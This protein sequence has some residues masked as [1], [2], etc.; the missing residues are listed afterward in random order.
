[1]LGG[2]NYSFDYG[3][4]ERYFA[5]NQ[6]ALNL[7]VPVIL[8]GASVGPFSK[9]PSYETWAAEQ[10]RKVSRIY[11]REAFT[12]DYLKTIGIEENVVRVVD[13][14]FLME[15]CEADFPEDILTFC[16][17]GAVGLNISPLIARFR[18]DNSLDSWEKLTRKI[19]QQIIDHLNLPIILI[20]HVTT[21]SS[22]PANDDYLFLKKVWEGL[23]EQEK[24]R[25]ALLGDNYD[26]A[27]TKW[28]ISKLKGFVGARTHATIASLSSAV[29]TIVIAYSIKG[30]GIV[31]DVFNDG[32]WLIEASD[33][34][35]EV[36][37]NKLSCLMQKSVEV[38]TYL[39][40]KAETLRARALLAAQD[41]RNF[42]GN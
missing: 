42:L 17:E 24:Q 15:P 18:P 7:K 35:P 31:Q 34:S 1:M 26:A 36:L 5:L 8:W 22:N 37:I 3:Y 28:L 4:P 20:P 10:L 9:D 13:P 30:R 38:R 23:T 40:A 32:E 16:A 33:F 39:N 2:D 19:I 21:Y 27:Q 12:V 14:A 25:V 11:A 6:L 41:V 29:P